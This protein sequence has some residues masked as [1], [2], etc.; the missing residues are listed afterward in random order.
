MELVVHDPVHGHVLEV[1]LA[2]TVFFL[3]Q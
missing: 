1:E 2:G 3:L